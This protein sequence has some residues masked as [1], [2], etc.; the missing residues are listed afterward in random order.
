MSPSTYLHNG[1]TMFLRAGHGLSHP[2]NVSVVPGVIVYQNGPVCH[3]SQ[4]VAVVPPRHHLGVLGSVKLEPIV[5]LS[6][7]VEYDAISTGTLGCQ[8][9]GGRGVGLT[10]DPC[11]VEDKGGQEHAY[12]CH[13]HSRYLK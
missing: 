5:R 12:N 1:V 9:D 7:V 4:L 6:E 8:D 3:G 11:A 2:R 10:G 13:H